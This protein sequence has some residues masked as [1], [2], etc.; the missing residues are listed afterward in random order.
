MDLRK[1][2]KLI[3]LVEESGISEL[4]VS[5]GDESIRIVMPNSVSAESGVASVAQFAPAQFAPAQFAPVQTAPK[6]SAPTQ[7]VIAPMAGVFYQAVN[8]EAQP[9]VALGQQV[10]AGEVLCIIES[11]KMMNEI[12]AVHA[13]TVTEICVA[14]GDAVATGSA[15]FKLL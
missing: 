15:L 14:N 11:M 4:E 9:F 3:E 7:N 13:G 6:Q 2:K 12:T 5:S 10:T 1:V 8:P